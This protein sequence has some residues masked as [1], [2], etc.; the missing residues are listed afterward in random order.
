[1]TSQ[2][3]HAISDWR[4]QIVLQSK[5]KLILWHKFGQNPAVGT[6]VEDVWPIGGTE[7][8]DNLDASART[9][10]INS[11]AADVGQVIRV[12]G[13]NASW[14]T[15]TVDVTLNGTTPVQVGD[16]LNWRRI[17][18]AFQVSAKPAAT[19]DVYMVETGGTYTAGVPDD[20]ALIHGFIDF[21]NAINQTEQAAFTVPRGYVGL[22]YGFNG[23][24][25]ASGGA[26]RTASV[27]L[28]VSDLADGATVD[29]P[30]WA[31]LR[32]I[33]HLALSTAADIAGSREEQTPLRVGELSVIR[34]RA[35]ATA[36][37]I[38]DAN[39]ELLLVP[40]ED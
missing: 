31:P 33:E 4:S 24:I 12:I 6:S 26:T 34:A 30:T 32:Q 36:T 17:N 23:S 18:R 39:F 15:I 14:D 19:G 10:D 9:I 13:L 2:H 25:R 22:I 37:S 40:M 29:S 3:Q 27:I 16:A 21:P 38:I 35:A 20:A 8:F 11:T 7:D 5:P 1:M 28:A